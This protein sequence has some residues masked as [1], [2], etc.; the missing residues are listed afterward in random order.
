MKKNIIG[1]C[2]N[3]HPIYRIDNNNAIC[4]CGYGFETSELQVDIYYTSNPLISIGWER[5]AP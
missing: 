2:P 4:E 1:Y 3:H 5:I